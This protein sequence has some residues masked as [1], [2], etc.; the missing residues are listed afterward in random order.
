MLLL[1]SFGLVSMLGHAGFHVLG[2]HSH[3][4][5]HDSHACAAHVQNTEQKACCHHHHEQRPEDHHSHLPADDSD[6]CV[7]CQFL[8]LTKYQ[9]VQP[10]VVLPFSTPVIEEVVQSNGVIVPFDFSLR[11]IPRGP[12]SLSV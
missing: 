3:C 11:P 1:L 10:T 6:D 8:A 5:S 9:I 12:P 2:L 7:V 4:Q